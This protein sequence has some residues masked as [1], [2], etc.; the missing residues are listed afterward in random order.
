M[1]RLRPIILNNPVILTALKQAWEDSLPGIIGGHEEGGF[2]LRDTAGNFSVFRWPKGSTNSII[3]PQHLNCQFD[4]KELLLHFIL[5]LI[6]AQIIYK[7]LA[8][9][10]KEQYA[11]I[12][13]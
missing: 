6:P 2:I 5:T 9:Q 7:S 3:L 10:I 1:S 13:I 12:P 11:M 4:D 8:K